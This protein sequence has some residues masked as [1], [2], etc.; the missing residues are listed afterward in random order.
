M[1]PFLKFPPFMKT[2][3]IPWIATALFGLSASGQV[4][5]TGSDGSLGD[6]EITTDTS[7]PLPPDGKLHY[8]SFKASNGVT[9]TFQ[10]NANNTPVYLL[11]QS[12]VVIDATFKLA[13]GNGTQTGLVGMGGP[14][15]FDG[16][17]SGSGGPPP[18]DGQG[19]G[20][21]RAG[22]EGGYSDP[23]SAGSG[24]H[25]YQ[26]GA[27]STNTGAIYGNAA[28]IPLVGG[29]GGGGTVRGTGGGGGGA[30]LVAAGTSIQ[31][32]PNGYINCTGGQFSLTG[33]HNG[34]SGGAVKLVAPKILG[35]VRIDVLNSNFTGS[36]GRARI[37]AFDFSGATF[38]I[39]RGLSLTT[40]SMMATGLE[41][42]P[43]SLA[44]MDVGGHP[45]ANG[46]STVIL[47]NG[48]AEQQNVTLRAAN[49]G[50]KV[51][52]EIVVTPVNGPRVT[53]LAEIDNSTVNPASTVVSVPFPG[54]SPARLDVWAR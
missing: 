48:S 45:V 32:G 23:G 22:N 2:P 54:N 16:G 29:S 15:G 18:G 42:I 24:S 33:A 31:F 47:P 1:N 17:H 39:N 38:K 4:F 30:I 10:K 6:V 41:G 8:R 27:G 49:F 9:I 40:G 53:V 20:G 26:L 14:G 12:N 11:S 28:L 35:E 52:V 25:L 3:L 51:P 19:P 34:G 46:A 50:T 21:G 43:P 7:I 36:D 37:D 44:I 5:N 13:G